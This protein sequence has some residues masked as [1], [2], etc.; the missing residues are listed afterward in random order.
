MNLDD[1]EPLRRN[2][3]RYLLDLEAYVAE[4]V[5]WTVRQAPASRC[6]MRPLGVIRSTS[7]QVRS[8]SI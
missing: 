4:F 3:S 6:S 2:T 7:P 5:P 8:H 1:W